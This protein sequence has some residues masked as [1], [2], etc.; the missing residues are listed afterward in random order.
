[1]AEHRFD[2][3]F[4]PSVI[5]AIGPNAT[6]RARAVFSSLITHLHDFARDIELTVDEWQMGMQWLDEVGH[7]YF[8]SNKTRHE[9]HR[10]S[11]VLGLERYAILSCN[12]P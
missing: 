4:T 5:S 10:I 7:I 8:T 12:K 9:M 1:M 11:D 3:N 2:P 6:P